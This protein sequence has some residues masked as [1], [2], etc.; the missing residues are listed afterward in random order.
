VGCHFPRIER[1]DPGQGFDWH[2]DNAGAD[3]ADRVIACLLYLSKVDQQG[4]TEFQHQN[5]KVKPEPG[6][7]V[8]FPPY[9]THLHRGISPLSETKYTMSFFWVYLDEKP[10]ASQKLTWSQRIKGRL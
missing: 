2:A 7:I 3:T 6:K 5:L 9:W 4:H 8:V 10:E 1:V